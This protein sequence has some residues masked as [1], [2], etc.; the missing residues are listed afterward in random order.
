MKSVLLACDQP[1]IFSY[2][3]N[4]FK[5]INIDVHIDKRYKL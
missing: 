5:N 4:N 3:D 2:V 1:L